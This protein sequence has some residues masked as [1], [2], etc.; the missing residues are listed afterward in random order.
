MNDIISSV[1][2]VGFPIVMCLLIYTKQNETI[3]NLRNS[4]EKNSNLIEKLI[5]KLGE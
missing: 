4:I 3:E 2:T 1:T 5:T